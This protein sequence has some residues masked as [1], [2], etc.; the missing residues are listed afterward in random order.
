MI[1]GSFHDLCHEHNIVQQKG[2]LLRQDQR[3][4]MRFVFTLSAYCDLQA[5]V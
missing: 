5:S 1:L 2:P 3:N 4:N